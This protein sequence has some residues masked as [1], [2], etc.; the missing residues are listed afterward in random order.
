MFE[1]D[2]FKIIYAVM[3]SLGLERLEIDKDLVL[4]STDPAMY[5][6]LDTKANKYIFN[7]WEVN[8]KTIYNI[9]E[10]NE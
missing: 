3:I 4:K 1:E 5:I 9:P 10:Q 2:F 6:T 8:D 7:C